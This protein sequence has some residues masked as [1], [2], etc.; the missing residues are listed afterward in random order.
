MRTLFS[1]VVNT[2]SAHQVEFTKRK[3]PHRRRKHGSCHAKRRECPV[4]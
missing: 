1:Y 4:D 2:N 3:S